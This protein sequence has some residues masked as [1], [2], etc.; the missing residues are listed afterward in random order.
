MSAMERV[1]VS[2]PP[3]VRQAAQR[4]ADDAGVSFSSVVNDA[5][6][7]WLR[8]RLVDEWL[9]EHQAEHGAFDEE[10]LRQLAADAGVPYLLPRPSRPVA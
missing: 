10:E 9:E 7:A 5:L 6:D 4:V 1:T 3:D 2:L 8:G